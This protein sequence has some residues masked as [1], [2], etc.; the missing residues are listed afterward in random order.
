[1]LLIALMKA[2][3]LKTCIKYTFTK[4]R[5]INKKA[6]KFRFEGFFYLFVVVISAVLKILIELFQRLFIVTG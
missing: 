6:L 4:N 2:K 3:G 1:M 5:R